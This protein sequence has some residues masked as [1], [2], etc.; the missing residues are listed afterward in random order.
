MGFWSC[1]FCSVFLKVALA[2]TLSLASVFSLLYV[3]SDHSLLG[4]IASVHLPEHLV[5]LQ[6]QVFPQKIK[7]KLL[8][9]CISLSTL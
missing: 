5:L 1:F 2:P 7:G 9:R 4:W 8:L 3:F 6:A